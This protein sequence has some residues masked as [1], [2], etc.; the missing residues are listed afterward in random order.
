MRWAINRCRSRVVRPAALD[1]PTALEGPAVRPRP[2]TSRSCRPQVCKQIARETSFK[3]YCLTLPRR[4]QL[5]PRLVLQPAL[6]SVPIHC[7]LKPF[8][9][10]LRRRKSQVALHRATGAGPASGQGLAELIEAQHFRLAA[11][12]AHRL[13]Y[14]RHAPG[15]GTGDWEDR[16]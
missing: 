6:A 3:T 12:L 4:R 7:F 13:A 5:G 15:H 1:R 14:A 8:T 16:R 10:P 9:K 2:C 11:E